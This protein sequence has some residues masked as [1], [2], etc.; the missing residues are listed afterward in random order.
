M[1]GEVTAAMSSLTWDSAS[2]IYSVIIGV[3]LARY[4]TFVASLLQ[5]PKAI[6]FYYPYLAFA[7]TSIL[8]LYHSWYIGKEF[9]T[10]IE[11]HA[12]SFALR[13]FMDAIAC[14]SAL[15]IIPKDKLLEDF[16][17]MKP[18]F[19]KVKRVFF[20]TWVLYCLAM[21]MQFVL[22]YFKADTVLW[23]QFYGVM[24]ICI[25]IILI[26][27]YVGS[28]FSKNDYY[29][30][31]HGTLMLVIILYNLSQLTGSSELFDY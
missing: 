10:I 25:V 18:W 26:P 19:M 23:Q 5:E 30:S 3:V 27:L 4:L 2:W 1:F 8:H 22:F 24:I 9:Y 17:D 20:F 12:L 15:I 7:L 16:F 11:G 31:F 21:I 14:I 6:K 29:L 13:T 28:A